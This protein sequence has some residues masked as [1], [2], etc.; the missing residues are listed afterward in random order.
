MRTT[1]T[2]AMLTLVCLLVGHVAV[3]VSAAAEGAEWPWWRGPNR[4]GKSPDKGLL[5]EWPAGGPK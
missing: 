1:R 2:A 5:K 4:D 3:S